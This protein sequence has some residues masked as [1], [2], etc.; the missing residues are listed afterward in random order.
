M[1]ARGIAKPAS[2]FVINWVCLAKLFLYWA[3]GRLSGARD[4]ILFIQLA[5]NISH[6]SRKKMVYFAWLGVDKKQGE[7]A[8]LLYDVKKAGLE[9][10]ISFLE[11]VE[12]PLPFFFAADIF[13]LVSREDP[14]PLV[15]LEAA[16]VGKP[17][18]CFQDAGGACEFVENDSGIVV[19]YLDLQAMARAICTLADDECPAPPMWRASS[20]KGLPKAR[21]SCGCTTA[22]FDHPNVIVTHPLLLHARCHFRLFAELLDRALDWICHTTPVSDADRQM[23]RRAARGA[24]TFALLWEAAQKHSFPGMLFGGFDLL[25]ELIQRE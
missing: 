14:F 10:R 6:L 12:K 15:M 20:R 11:P 4:Q 23:L 3:V 24:G 17:V 21:Y 1:I 25:D 16:S 7:F 9:N 19:P 2:E 8:K 5:Y 13:A 22:S 18:V